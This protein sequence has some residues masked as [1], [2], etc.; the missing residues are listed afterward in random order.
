MDES[1]QQSIAQW[2]NEADPAEYLITLAKYSDF[3]L[4][5]GIAEMVQDRR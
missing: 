2:L 3:G 4:I 5:D 1:L